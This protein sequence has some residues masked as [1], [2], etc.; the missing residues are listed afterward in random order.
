M[1]C[2]IWLLLLLALEI[3]LVSER[4]LSSFTFISALES[5]KM[6]FVSVSSLL[7]A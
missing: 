3:S 7:A 5:F 1:V 4:I 6:F 2:S